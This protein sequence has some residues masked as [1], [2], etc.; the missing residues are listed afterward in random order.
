MEI[1][2]IVV[3]ADMTVRGGAGN[4]T[5]VIGNLSQSVT[6]YNKVRAGG[7]SGIVDQA[8][9]GLSQQVAFAPVIGQKADASYTSSYDSTVSLADV[10]VHAGWG[11]WFD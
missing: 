4:A 7:H 10:N 5:N 11:R 3:E 1:K 8:T 2:D 9:Q 6:G